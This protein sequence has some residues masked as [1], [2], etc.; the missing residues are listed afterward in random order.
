MTEEPKEPRVEL[1]RCD[2]GPWAR[3]DVGHWHVSLFASGQTIVEADFSDPPRGRMQVCTSREAA[4]ERWE[5]LTGWEHGPSREE[6]ELALNRLWT[7]IASAQAVEED[8]H[9]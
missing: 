1:L 8:A 4:I 9:R 7:A 3:W 2:S 5:W 6:L